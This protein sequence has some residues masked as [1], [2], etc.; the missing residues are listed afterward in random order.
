MVELSTLTGAV[1]IALGK[2]HG[3]LFSNSDDLCKDLRKA[4]KEVD[5]ELWRLPVD[6][7]HHELIKSKHA[8]ITNAPGKIDAASSQ[9]AA[10]LESF[11]E[12]GVNW[13]HLDIAGTSK[14]AE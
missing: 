6:E 14:K 13:A 12:K 5:E 8:D 4:G 1:V 9:A 7:Y 3:G 2:K 10:F 11:V